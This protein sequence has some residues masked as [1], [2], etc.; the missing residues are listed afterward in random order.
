MHVGQPSLPPSSGVRVEEIWIGGIIGPN[1]AG[2][3]FLAVIGLDENILIETIG[4]G[5]VVFSL[6]DSCVDD[7]DVVHALIVE[8]LNKFRKVFKI[9]SIVFKILVIIHPINI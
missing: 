5:F 3:S 8:T 1:S 6:G 2:E 9:E 4:E 7:R